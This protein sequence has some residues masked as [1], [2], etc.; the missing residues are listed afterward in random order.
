VELAGVGEEDAGVGHEGDR[1]GL[2]G[3]G[4]MVSVL[5]GAGGGV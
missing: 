1:V 2:A 5:V 4:L 3:A